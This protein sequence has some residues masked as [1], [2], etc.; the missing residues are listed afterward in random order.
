[1]RFLRFHG[2][3]T[4]IALPTA[5]SAMP[6]DEALDQLRDGEEL[7]GCVVSGL[8]LAD[9]HLERL[10]LR[11]CVVDG[12]NLANATVDDLR[13]DRVVLTDS[14]MVG[15]RAGASVLDGTLLDACRLDLAML[16]GLKLLGPSALVGCSLREADLSEAAARDAVVYDCDLSGADLRAA[17]FDG[18]DLR[19]SRLTGAAGLSALR[20]VV[21]DAGQLTDLILD[22]QRELG[23]TVNDDDAG[24]TVPWRE[25][26]EG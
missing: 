25:V 9:E 3:D 21:L 2:S 6:S 19:G 18:A 11:N 13:L 20:R 22:V 14:T 16:S 17:R 10:A 5:E 4:K 23:L 26:D 7:W 1:V 24:P 12:A 8:D 15:L